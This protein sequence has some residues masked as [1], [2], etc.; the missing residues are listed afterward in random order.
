MS[1]LHSFSCRGVSCVVIEKRATTSNSA[2][3]ALINSNT[4]EHMRRLGLE[5]PL[6]EAS[7]PRNQPFTLTLGTSLLGE[8]PLVS[9]LF[10]SWGDAM[11]G[12]GCDEDMPLGFTKEDTAMPSIFCPQFEQ[13]RVL[14]EHL[15]TKSNVRLLWGKTAKSV[16]ESN[17]EVRVNIM[18]TSDPSVETTVKGNYLIACDGGRSWIRKQ[19][20]V[21]NI[22]RFVVKRACTFVINSKEA[23]RQLQEKG[24]LGFGMLFT[25]RYTAVNI[26]LNT[27]GDFAFHLLMPP[28]TPDD[29]LSDMCTNADEVVRHLLGKDVPF[30]VKDAHEYNMHA[31]ISTKFRIGRVFF[32]GDA[33]HQ[34]LPAGGLGLNTGYQD[35][36]DLGWK[37]AAVINGWGGPCLLDSYQIER[38]PIADKTRRFAMSIAPPDLNIPARKIIATALKKSP[39]LRLFFYLFG[40]KLLRAF[41]AF[42]KDIVLGNQYT[43]TN[44]VVHE[45]VDEDS[46]KTTI[47]TPHEKVG[48]Y[49]RSCLPGSRAPH[50]MLPESTSIHDIFGKGFI[51]LIIGGQGTDCEGLQG[52]LKHRKVPFDVHVYPK[53]PEFVTLYDCKYYLIR[54]DGIIAWRSYSQ[55]SNHQSEIIVNTICGDVP[56]H[57]L[58][59]PPSSND[60]QSVFSFSFLSNVVHGVSAGLFARRYTSITQLGAVC[61]G[62]GVATLMSLTERSKPVE[63]FPQKISRH[64]AW[65]VTKFGQPENSLHLENKFM[66]DFGPDDILIKVHAASLN[67]IDLTMRQGRNLNVLKGLARR[68]KSGSVLPVVLGRDCSG[69]VLAVGDNT[70]KSFIPGDMVYAA[71]PPSIYGTH[72]QYACINEKYVSLK[73]TN[74]DHAQAASLPWVAM[75][76]WTAV[77]E[78]AG[79][80]EQSTRCKKVLVHGGSGGVGSFAIQM[81]RAW[82]AEVTTTCSKDNLQLVHGLGAD[83]AIDYKSCDF[84]QVLEKHSYDFVLDI[85]GSCNNYEGR[86]IGLLKQYNGAKYVSLVCPRDHIRS[87]CGS[88]IGDVVF[89]WYYRYK[90][91]KN[92]FFGGRGFYYTHAEPSAEALERVKGMVEVGDIR[93]C[94][95]SVYSIEEM[96]D[97]HQHLEGGSTYGKV[98]VSFV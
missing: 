77:V 61:I 62:M 85:F 96:V 87:T 20:D 52:L 93:P 5:R 7:Y 56:F 36:S 33:A 97:A 74:V 71:C 9:V 26:G 16:E 95:S 10:S 29:V 11:D 91:F 63:V 65:Q 83:K 51:L 53:L 38:R 35:A 28:D 17:D 42:N 89:Q 39:V 12:L 78:Q 31:L 76:T 94:V 6:L 64:Q 47:K 66:R 68:D 43:E 46:S 23:T 48:K 2:R 86:S 79:L 80:T 57:S 58:K 84:Y 1:S 60:Q 82:G 27:R 14:K 41:L 40:Q 73:P 24:N 45:Y 8:A 70:R 88:F 72:A 44:I 37:L 30:T 15:E 90:I 50:L 18:D 67:Q 34:W 98:V 81:L 32:A 75:T 19:M 69:E 3:A 49:S 59:K 21:H 92:R 55:P 25:Q 54:P 4:M 22:G 13:E